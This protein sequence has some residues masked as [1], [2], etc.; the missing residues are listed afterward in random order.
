MLLLLPAMSLWS[1]G[2]L[3][4]SASSSALLLRIVTCN[5]RAD[6]LT[7]ALRKANE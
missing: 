2:A 5:D 3:Y 7:F 1:H 6:V 4:D